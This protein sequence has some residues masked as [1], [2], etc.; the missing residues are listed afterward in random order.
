MG[1]FSCSREGAEW[2]IKEIHLTGEKISTP[3]QFS[4]FRLL[5]ASDSLCLCDVVSTEHSFSVVDCVQNVEYPF[6]NIGRGPLEV[7]YAEAVVRGEYIYVLS[8]NQLTNKALLKIP[9]SS[10]EDQQSWVY[11]PIG[12][13]EKMA[14]AGSFDIV[15]SNNIIATTDCWDA[16]NV[17]SQINLKEG[18]YSPLNFWPDD[19]VSESNIVKRQMYSSNS[20]IF[21]RGSKVLYAAGEG[22]YVVILDLSGSEIK[23]SIILNEK[24]KYKV[25]SDGINW[26]RLPGC[27]MGVKATATDSLIYLSPSV[28]MLEDH[29][30]VP[31]NYKGYPPYF[32]DHIHVYDWEGNYKHTY[33]TDV[34]ISSYYVSEE[35]NVMYALT[36]DMESGYSLIYRYILK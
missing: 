17:L 27:K 9:I 32:I 14:P 26:G 5:W 6:V 29:A 33:I 31:D 10:F 8:S 3:D 19:E 20:T 35:D 4:A 24:P 1:L 13:L 23:E 15:D 11:L 22:H 34:P 36:Q 25:L 30:Y 28:H 2:S 21:H 7:I 16:A 12:G 18:T